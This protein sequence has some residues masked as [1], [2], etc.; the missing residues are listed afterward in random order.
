MAEIPV[1]SDPRTAFIEAATWRGSLERAEAI[2]ARHP[3]IAS[4]DIHTA[5]IVGAAAAV[6]QFL[7]QDPTSVAAKSPPYGGDAL[8]YLG[9]S[10]YLRLDR[11][12]SDVPRRGDA[13]V[14]PQER[15][16]AG[17]RLAL[18]V[19]RDAD[20][21]HA[22]LVAKGANV[23]GTPVSHPWGLRDFQVLDLEGNRITFGQPFEWAGARASG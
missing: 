20:A 3:D 23:Q 10:K 16:A 22:E 6:R 17:H 21:V 5:A 15:A 9:L 11:T 8:T 13:S 1:A 18:C 2:L 12:R 7:E 4:G 14:D 19:R